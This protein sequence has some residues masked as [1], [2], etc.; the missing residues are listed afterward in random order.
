MDL[1]KIGR[2]GME[3]I[4][5]AQDRDR[6]WAIANSAMNIRVFKMRCG[7]IPLLYEKLL[8]YREGLCPTKRL[9]EGVRE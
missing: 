9:S 6:W 1:E 4:D 2:D 3:L 5:L 7:G 8:N